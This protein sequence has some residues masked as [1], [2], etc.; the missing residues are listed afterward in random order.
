M[1]VTRDSDQMP[2]E[3]N[4]PPAGK[5][6]RAGMTAVGGA[7]P[8]AGGLFSAAAG[9]WS[10]N[11]QEGALNV[12]RSWVKMLEDELQ[13][14]QRTMLDVMAR[15]DMHDEEI[16]ARVRSDEY[17]SIIKKAFRNWA[18]TESRKKQEYIRN[19]L[20][21]A[22]ATRLVSDDVVFLFMD[23]LQEYS[24]FHFAVIG[25]LYAKQ[26]ATRLQIW[27]NLGR[28]RVRE[29]SAD[30][31]LFKLL[32]RDLSTGGI[33]R[34]HRETDH[35]GNFITRS[36]AR[37][38]SR[39]KS[40]PGAVKVAKS[41]FDDRERY[42]LT[43]IGEQFVHYAMTE[44]TLKLGFDAEGDG[45]TDPAGG[46]PPTTPSQASSDASEPPP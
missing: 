29:D 18:G 13:E 17:Q 41:A 43:A 39:S 35:R 46:P 10:E 25:E 34:Q 30:A 14:K 5:W 12:L 21:N 2:D 23:W 37:Q 6:V 4:P 27:Q 16:A 7:I 15:L 3:L 19:I 38:G 9:V 20:N 26:G 36:P 24:E 45:L 40:A 28:D 22:A 44:L 8:F 31:D 42:E 32:I 11:E 33:I 1:A